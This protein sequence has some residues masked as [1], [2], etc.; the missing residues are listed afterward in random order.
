MALEEKKRIT[1][2][3]YDLHASEWVRERSNLEYC[4]KEFGEFQKLLPAGKVIDLGCGT[5]RDASLFV[6]KGYEYTGVDISSGMIEEAKKLF[7]LAH[8]REMDLSSLDF[9]DGTFDGI[10]SFGAYLHIPKDEILGAIREANRVLR[11]GGIGFITVKKGS[12]ERY[13]GEGDAKRYW[14]FYGKNQ[15]ADVLKEGGFEVITSWE[16]KRD[17]NPPDDLSVFLCYFVRKP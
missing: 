2:E 12:F 16:D 1:K 4:L 10:W 6:P 14:S 9:P 11:H 8:F 7:P 17:Y 13:L 5:G 3:Y 15:F